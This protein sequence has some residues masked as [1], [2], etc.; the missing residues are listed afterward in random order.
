M[1]GWK[2]SKD[3]ELHT[4]ARREGRRAAWLLYSR[5]RSCPILAATHL[6]EPHFLC[7]EASPLLRRH[8]QAGTP[9]HRAPPVPRAAGRLQPLPEQAAAA[10]LGWNWSAGRG[11]R[12]RM[13][14]DHREAAPRP[15]EVA[16]APFAVQH[17]LQALQLV[18][19]HGDGEAGGLRRRRHLATL[20]RLH[21]AR[22]AALA[23][24]LLVR[25]VAGSRQGAGRHRRSACD[26]CAFHQ[27]HQREAGMQMRRLQAL[28]TQVGQPGC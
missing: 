11:T 3:G 7:T 8:L 10:G 4:G 27:E 18:G 20:Q 19:A 22:D 2:D 17:E 5:S 15:P 12:F 6:T 21:Q 16:L 9:Q 13:C 14:G 26:Q 23:A 1:H 28:P 24:L 25:P